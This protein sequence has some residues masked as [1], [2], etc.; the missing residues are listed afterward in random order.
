MMIKRLFSQVVTFFLLIAAC[1]IPFNY[2]IGSKAALFSYSTMA[3]PAFGN[4]VSLLYVFLLILTK[5]LCSLSSFAALFFYAMHR[6]PLLFATIAF[7]KRDWKIYIAL[8]LCSMILFCVHPIGYQVFYYSFY[9]LIPM[10]IYAYGV[11]SLPSR[12]LA[13]S[14]V[15][16][17]VG[18]VIWLY[19]KVIPQELWQAL[20]PIVMIERLAIAGGMIGFSYLFLLV[21]NFCAKKVFA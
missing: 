3:V 16:H 6:L 19:T 11:D 4:Y 17:C 14:F 13:A 1:M 8:P 5:G 18:S 9:W 21:S 2:I 15:A 20:I 7:Q 10:A 12:A